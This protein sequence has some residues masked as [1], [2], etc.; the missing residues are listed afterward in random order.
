MAVTKEFVQSVRRRVAEEPGVITGQL[1]REL[2]APEAQVITAL[3]VAMRKKASPGDFPVIWERMS[4]WRH[5]VINP[6]KA[7]HGALIMPGPVL[8]FG[9][10]CNGATTLRNQRALGDEGAFRESLGSIWFVS[11]PLAGGRSHSVRFF[12]REGNHMLSVFLGRD[13]S[14]RHD[15]DALRDF[16]ELR[17]RHGI[18]PVPKNRCKGCP[19]CT[20]GLEGK[21]H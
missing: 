17:E 4:A 15:K 7:E 3:P 14:G 8:T 12:D 19:G 10:L 20:C 1:A 18:T 9:A 11:L 13:R 16:E 21:T 2:R 5:A 6:A